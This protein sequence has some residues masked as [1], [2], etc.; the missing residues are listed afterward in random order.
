MLMIPAK[1]LFSL[2]LQKYPSLPDLLNLAAGPD[3]ATREL[4]LRYL[5]DKFATQY[6]NYQPG[7]FDIAFIPAIGPDGKEFLAKHNQVSAPMSL[8]KPCLCRC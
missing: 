2:G 8:Y 5:F 4:A 6:Q 1:F 3:V 7:S